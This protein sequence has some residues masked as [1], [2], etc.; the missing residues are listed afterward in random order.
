MFA[1][2]LER[3]KQRKNFY[4]DNYRRFLYVLMI[5]LIIIAALLA[6]ILSLWTIYKVP[7]YYATSTDGKLWQIEPAKWGARL[8][9]PAQQVRFEKKQQAQ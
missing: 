2:E 6:G 3:V 1:E 4:R 9:E 5:C 8:P 7:S